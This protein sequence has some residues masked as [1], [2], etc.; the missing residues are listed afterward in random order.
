VN[1]WQIEA[2]YY[3]RNEVT[4]TSYAQA[5]AI[6][7]VNPG[8]EIV[9]TIRFDVANGTMVVSVGDAKA[10]GTRTSAITISRPFPNDPSLFASWA[11]FFKKAAAESRTSLR[12]QHDRGGRR[13]VLSR[14]ADHVRIVAVPT[15]QNIDSGNWREGLGI[16]D[17]AADRTN[18]QSTVCATSILDWL[19]GLDLNQDY[20]IGP[21]Y[22][23]RL[24]RPIAYAFPRCAKY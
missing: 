11:D 15:E 2:Q 13:T 3:W 22:I 5:G 1:R 23:I 9:T 4:S 12:H 20:Q 10:G 19:G 6:V 24:P 17:P 7:T 16:F 14:R 8:D 18:L 21:A